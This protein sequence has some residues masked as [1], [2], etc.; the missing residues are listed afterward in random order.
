[1]NHRM[2]QLGCLLAVSMLFGG[3]V[4]TKNAEPAPQPAPAE[5]P[6]EAPVATM[7]E[8]P[9]AAPAVQPKAAPKPAA[10]KAAPKAA[11]A[12]A[13]A[14]EKPCDLYDVE[15]AM[16]ETALT[17]GKSVSLYVHVK[18]N[19]FPLTGHEAH[20][21]KVTFNGLG[22]ASNPPASECLRVHPNGSDIIYNVT[23]AN[24]GTYDV[25]ANVAFYPT[26]DCNASRVS[27]M[28]DPLTVTVK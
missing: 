25:V 6:S 8:A 11:P 28:S 19:G 10:S 26:R 22:F 3:C 24:A 27:K 21:V 23:A 2:K 20:G 13:P 7:A 17:V 18:A 1:M 9:A 14:E 16:D 4:A 12:A 5:Q 15:V